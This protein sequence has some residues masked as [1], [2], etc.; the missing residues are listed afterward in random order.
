MHNF[1]AYESSD[2]LT[3]HVTPRRT[4]RTQE[5]IDA[6]LTE[7]IVT[8]TL[9]TLDAYRNRFESLM[10]PVN[11]INAVENYLEYIEDYIPGDR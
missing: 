4:R 3:R 10:I 8:E 9:D 1:K 11:D 5:Q 7:D 6:Q 2:V